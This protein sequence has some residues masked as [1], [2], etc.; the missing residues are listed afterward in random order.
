MPPDPTELWRFLPVG[1]VLSVAIETPVLFAG[2]SNQHSVARRILAGLWLTACTY[3]IVVL[4]LPELIW[5]PL[6]EAGYWPYVVLAEIFA[7][8]AE[9]GLFWMAYW[10]GVPGLRS[11]L[12]RD[13]TS[14]VAAN[15]A[16]FL[17]GG[18]I[19]SDW[20]A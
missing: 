20:W 9:C 5:R 3:P 13:M 4:V 17:I 11:D 18:W 7:P 2:L 19:A 8:A 1:Y 16:S 15:L 10:R 12:L 6:G 14:I